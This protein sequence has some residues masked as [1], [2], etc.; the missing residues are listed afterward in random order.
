MYDQLY[1]FV[2]HMIFLLNQQQDTLESSSSSLREISSEKACNSCLLTCGK[3]WAISLTIRS[4]ISQ[5]ILNPYF[6]SNSDATDENLIYRCVIFPFDFSRPI[7]L[8]VMLLD[9][10]GALNKFSDL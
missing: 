5:E 10:D 2:S 3:A 9:P 7:Y 4:A 6:P 8:Y 1:E